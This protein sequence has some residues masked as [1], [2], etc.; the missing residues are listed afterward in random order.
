MTD[1]SKQT[2]R[3]SKKISLN[4]NQEFIDLA[5]NLRKLTNQNRTSIFLA[6]IGK[7]IDPLFNDMENT[8]R[9]VLTA[10]NLNLSKEKK[11]EI[12]KLLKKLKKIRKEWNWIISKWLT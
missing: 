4:M 10:G 11:K 9:G 5:D 2:L 6:W 7:G 1:I 3:K 12:E 8:W